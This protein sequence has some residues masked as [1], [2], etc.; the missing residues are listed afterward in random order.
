MTRPSRN[1]LWDI[2]REVI[3]SAD[4]VDLTH[5]FGPG[6][7]RFSSFPDEERTLVMDFDRG[8]IAQVH[9]YSFVGQWGTHVD[10]PVHFVNGGRALD[11][12]PVSEMLLPLVVIDISERVARD[13]DATPTMEDLSKWEERHGRIPSG[14]FVALRTDWHT[15]WPDA[16]KFA[17]LGQDGLSHAPGWSRSA[18]ETLLL[19]RG[20]T[21]I[22]HEQIDTDPGL[23]VS[24]GDSG[25][26]LFVLQQN[27]WQIELLRNLDKVPE[28]GALLMASWPKPKGGSGFPARAIAIVPR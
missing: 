25:L 14:C 6:Q 11:E 28:A 16:E 23:A 9:R 7:P 8:D 17:N 12:L 4:F 13:P 22:G 24:R 15:R 19:E 1:P 10:P 2:Y 5:A 18:L 21:A 20:V 26:E 27:A 3:S